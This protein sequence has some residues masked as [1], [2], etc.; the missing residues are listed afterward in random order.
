[1]TSDELSRLYIWRFPEAT[2]PATSWRIPESTP[3]PSRR[4][5]NLR[6][7]R[8]MRR[9]SWSIR[10]A[11]EEALKLG[12]LARLEMITDLLTLNMLALWLVRFLVFTLVTITNT[13]CVRQ[14]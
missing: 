10:Q 11:L 6:S 1:M 4:N 8:S 3:A 13:R 9:L 5:V 12:S 2:S 14:I 7:E